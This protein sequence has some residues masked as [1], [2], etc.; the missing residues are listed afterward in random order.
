MIIQEA[1][2]SSLAKKEQGFIL[3]LDMENAYHRVNISFLSAILNQF[4]FSIKLIEII[5]ACIVGLWIA[6]LINGRSCE[7]FQRSQGLRQGCLLSP[8]IYIL[9]AD[10]LSKN[11]GHCRRNCALTGLSISS[12]TKS[13]NH[14]FFANET[15]LMGRASCIVA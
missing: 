13:I 12:G 4:N 1:L 3:K 15:L 8:F 9:M 6:P 14:S 2:H 10:S 5:N 7:Y 11:L